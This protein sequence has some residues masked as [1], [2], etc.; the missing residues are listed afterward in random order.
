MDPSTRDA[1]AL[2][3]D[4][5]STPAPGRGRLVVAL[6]GPASSGKSS[7][8]AAAALELGYR[9]VDTGLLYRAVTWLSLLRDVAADDP[10]GLVA[11]VGEVELT[12]DP[13]GRLA[14]VMVDDVDRTAE[15][16][17]EAVDQAVSAVSRVPELRAAL[18]QRQREIAGDGGIVMAGR[19]IGTVVLPDADL[20]V[21]LDAS[22]EERA[23]RRAE[24]RGLAPDSPEAIEILEQLRARDAA[25]RNRS[26]APL[27]PADDARII[28]TDGNAFEDTVREVVRVIRET[29]TGQAKGSVAGAPEAASE[30]L[31]EAGP[32]AAPRHGSI[33]SHLTPMITGVALGARVVMSALTRVR[34]EGALDEIPRDGPVIFAANHASNADAF[35]VGG[36]LVPMLGRRLHWLAKKEVFSWPVLGWMAAH[37]GMHP[38]D[39]STADVE[40]FRLA[41]RILDE[42]HPLFVFPEGTRSPDGKLQDARDGVAMLALRTGATIVPIGVGGSDRVWPRNRRLPR[43]GGRVTVRF[44]RPFRLADELPRDVRGRAA[45]GEATRLL[46]RRIAALLPERQRGAYADPR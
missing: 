21:F 3:L 11:L 14:R 10:A 9:F 38:V 16:H 18:L 28:V 24:E 6:D 23:R 1:A 40:A 17:T 32:V 5:R 37:G 36:W 15:V 43:P 26:V 34:V 41:K 42:G 33:E 13:Q 39:R 44:G 2:P 8:G 46:M 7:V 19:D 12:P 27:R 20:K 29:E 45:K 25:D 35:L 22:A 31:G 4:D 30:P